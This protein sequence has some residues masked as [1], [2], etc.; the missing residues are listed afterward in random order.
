VIIPD[1]PCFPVTAQL[2]AIAVNPSTPIAVTQLQ[3]FIIALPVV[4]GTGYYWNLRNP[5]S[6]VQP[7]PPQV[8]RWL[9]LQS[10]P[11]AAYPNPA[12]TAGTPPIVGGGATDLFLFTA[13][14]GGRTQLIFDL[15]PP[16][17]GG[18]T[19]ASTETFTVNVGPRQIV[20]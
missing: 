6:T 4:Q 5:Q 12:A 1:V 3:P 19:P 9:G 11:A 17:A 20:C 13:D 8:A 16:G 2:A 18:N 14:N 7:P 10:I 15:L